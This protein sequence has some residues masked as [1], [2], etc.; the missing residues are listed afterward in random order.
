MNDAS[1]EG[2]IMR[3]RKYCAAFH[4]VGIFSAF[5][6]FTY[7]HPLAKSDY[8]ASVAN[9]RNM[10]GCL[11]CIFPWKA[12]KMRKQ[13]KRDLLEALMIISVMLFGYSLGLAA[14]I[15]PQIALFIGLVAGAI[16][17]YFVSRVFD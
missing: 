3:Q 14:N 11:D 2:I 12:K 16:V 4:S 9:S 15:N 8:R 10:W 6:W 7:L 1:G 17:T 5:D 13:T